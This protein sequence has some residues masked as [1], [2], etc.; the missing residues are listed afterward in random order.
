MDEG[1]V[2]LV[3]LLSGADMVLM[4][5]AALPATVVVLVAAATGFAALAAYLGHVLAVFADRFAAYAAQLTAADI[6]IVGAGFAALLT[7]L[8][9]VL[10]VLADGFAAFAPS[11]GMTLRV[12]VPSATFI[13]AVVVCHFSVPFRTGLRVPAQEYARMG[14]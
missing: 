8:R 13:I 5:A 14:C 6:G 2:V 4:G 10:A 12:A 1:L 11:L 9:H 7:D 3:A